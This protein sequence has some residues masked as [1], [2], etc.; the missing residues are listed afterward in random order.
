MSRCP[1]VV[2]GSRTDTGRVPPLGIYGIW[3]RIPATRSPAVHAG[4]M[5]IIPNEAGAN[6]SSSIS[7]C[8]AERMLARL[9]AAIT[10][11]VNGIGFPG[12]RVAAVLG[13]GRRKSGKALNTL[14]RYLDFVS[15]RASSNGG[16]EARDSTAAFPH[17]L[18]VQP[19]VFQSGVASHK[20]LSTGM[21]PTASIES[22][23]LGD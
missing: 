4:G 23:F 6:L 9:I 19:M 1:G 15:E 12:T 7:S 18:D 11:L 14:S 5:A 20:A 10:C 3:G 22:R 21:C 17:V 8:W 2:T 16:D 13:A